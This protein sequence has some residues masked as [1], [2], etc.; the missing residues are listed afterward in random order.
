MINSYGNQNKDFNF[1]ES[2]DAFL[3]LQPEKIDL[4]DGSNK[5]QIKT[6]SKKWFEN[7]KAITLLREKPFG[8]LDNF[9]KQRITLTVFIIYDYKNNDTIDIKYFFLSKE[10][11]IVFLKIVHN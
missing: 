6:Q 1:N 2:S 5:L 3:R 4:I 9:F 8:N 10:N 7:S 11:L